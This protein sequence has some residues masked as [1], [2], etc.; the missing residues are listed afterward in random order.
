[1][2]EDGDRQDPYWRADALVSLLVYSTWDQVS[3]RRSQSSATGIASQA[4][5]GEEIGTV[6]ADG[7]YVTRRGPTTI[8][9][10]HTGAIILVR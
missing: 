5:N 4:L 1:M 6:P 2:T 3:R 7:A 8:I 10:L 9:N